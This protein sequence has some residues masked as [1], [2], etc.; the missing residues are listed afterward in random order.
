[1]SGTT[2]GQTIGSRSTGGHHHGD[3]LLL[4]GGG[5][6]AVG[7]LYVSKTGRNALGARGGGG[8]SLLGGTATPTAAHAATGWRRLVRLFHL[9]AVERFR[10]FAPVIAPISRSWPMVG[11]AIHFSAAS[12]V[13][14][15]VIVVVL[16][17]GS[18]GAAAGAGLAGR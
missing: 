4:G 2:A 3:V 7:P 5:D 11:T 18:G 12:R 9:L 10:H 6:A 15:V 16:G 17:V 13:I 8:R 1:M 14:V